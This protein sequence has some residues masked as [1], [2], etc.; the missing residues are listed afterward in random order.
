MTLHIHNGIGGFCALLTQGLCKNWDVLQCFCA[1]MMRFCTQFCTEKRIK[2]NDRNA[3]KLVQTMCQPIS[4]CIPIFA[5]D[6]A[7]V[8]PQTMTKKKQ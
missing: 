1:E 2:I 4:V 6:S 7:L 3:P 8:L 5:R